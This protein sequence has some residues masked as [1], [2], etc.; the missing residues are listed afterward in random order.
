MK[1]IAI[2]FKGLVNEQKDHTVALLNHQTVIMEKEGVQKR[3]ADLKQC[4]EEAQ[5]SS[6]H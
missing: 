6:V 3:F 5:V 4:L 1:K 2:H